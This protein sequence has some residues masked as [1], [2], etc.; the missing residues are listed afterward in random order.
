MQEGIQLYPGA[1]RIGTVREHGDFGLGTF[2]DLDGEMV[3]VNGHLLQVRS[4][5]S[6]REVQADVLSPF[7]A[8]SPFS[9]ESDRTGG[10]GGKP[11][12]ALGR[13]QTP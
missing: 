1:V 12:R 10:R 7:A 8:V 9:P 2:E 11:V 5:G 6:V 4:D 13:L 3:I